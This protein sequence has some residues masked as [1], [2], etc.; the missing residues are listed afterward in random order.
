MQP[1]S[2]Q[3]VKL[4]RG[5]HTSPQDGVCV[6]E[7]ASMLA[8]ESFTDHPGSVSPAIASFLRN[9]NDVLDDRRRQDL[10]EY[11]A[12]AVGTTGSVDDERRRVARLLSWGDEVWRQRWGWM[13]LGRLRSR[14]VRGDRWRYPEAAARYALDAIG[15][16]SDDKHAAALALVDELI[17]LGRPRRVLPARPSTS[18]IALRST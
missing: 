16:L 14:I 7:L 15:K 18:R 12:K 17:A 5:R 8:G 1:V 9:Y 4:G 3:T 2:H 10:Y 11:A 13:I 6:M